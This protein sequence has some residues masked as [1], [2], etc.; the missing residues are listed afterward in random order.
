MK[1]IQKNTGHDWQR[2]NH[3][4]LILRSVTKDQTMT[5]RDVLIVT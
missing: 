1:V 2:L 5:S 4:Q 3:E